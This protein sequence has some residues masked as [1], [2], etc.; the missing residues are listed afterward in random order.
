MLC[1][2]FIWLKEEDLEAVR[3]NIA[4]DEHCKIR[5]IVR[6]NGCLRNVCKV[7]FKVVRL[8]NQINILDSIDVLTAKWHQFHKIDSDKDNGNEK[9]NE[10]CP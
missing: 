4:D 5:E 1:C 6:E 2:Y 3:I 7:K 10:I 9:L 8:L